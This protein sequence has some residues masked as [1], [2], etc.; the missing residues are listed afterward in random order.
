MTRED[1]IAA[2]AVR[3]STLKSLKVKKELRIKQIKQDAEE[4]IREVN[5]QYADDPERLRAKYAADDFFN[6]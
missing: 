5:I 2:K 6:L 4:K 1:E 3:L